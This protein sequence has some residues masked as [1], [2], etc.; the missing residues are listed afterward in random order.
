MTKT[1]SVEQVTLHGETEGGPPG[2]AVAHP[3]AGDQGELHA[4]RI[5]GSAAGA[6]AVE[7]VYHG[8]PIQIAP[9]RE[10]HWEAL[11]GLV[12]LRAD[13]ALELQ[14]VLENGERLPAA[15]LQL[16]RTP[17]RSGFE[18][19]MQPLLLTSLG[20]SGSTWLMKMFAAHPEIVVMRRFPYES[21]A[22]KYWMHA[23][24]VL[25]DPASI[26]L[27]AHPDSFHSDRW[28]AGSNPY[29]D[30]PAIE[31]PERAAWLAREH[32]ERLAR[33]FQ[34]SVE[35]WYVTVAHSQGQERPRYFA[36][37]HLWPNFL[38]MLMRELYPDAREIFLVRDFRDVALSA[39]GTDARRG[40]AG[41]GKDP[42]MSDEDYVRDVVTRMATDL[43]R[44]WESRAEGAHLVRYEDMAHRPVETLAGLLSY[45]DVDAAP[46]TVERLLALASQ[47]VPDLPGSSFDPE[48]VRRHR[49]S[50]SPQDSIGRWRDRDGAFR[51]VLDEAL[52]DALDAFGYERERGSSSASQNGSASK[53]APLLP[54]EYEHLIEQVRETADAAIPRNA[55][56]LVVS[57]GD[58]ELLRIGPRRALHF[59]QDDFGGYAGYH[60]QDSAAAIEL[61]EDM[62]ARGAQ[63]LVL[64]RTDFWWLDFYSGLDGHLASN[65]PLIA[66]NGECKVFELVTGVQTPLPQPDE[67]A[68]RSALPSLE[69]DELLR[70]LLPTD[71]RV[72]VVTGGGGA[73][74]PSFPASF[75]VPAP[76]EDGG[77]DAVRR[78]AERERAEFLVIPAVARDRVHMGEMPP[79]SSGAWRI[80]TRQEHV[81]DVWERDGGRQSAV[82]SRQTPDI[83][84]RI[85]DLFGRGS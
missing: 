49:G 52:G 11:V 2:F 35:Q 77:L 3:R 70:A 30:P 24:K 62:R 6:R 84:R 4:L 10:A 71:A 38:P 43:R 74:L 17:L 7:I 48:L 56:V 58:E 59:P 51:A 8:R 69:L 53:S 14:V 66:S 15:T 21:S 1:Y 55:T 46:A 29:F 31:D 45:L 41:F 42:G 75:P 33:F 73:G 83:V 20:R 22:A 57:R 16:R 64:P 37:K 79:E 47:D 72:A 13:A 39:L 32:V 50:G 80:V 67:T 12:G 28:W 63:Y 81:G 61:L 9:V 60:P 65:Y 85:M 40:Y 36:E 25:S 34:E 26:D 18:P 23:M 27:S 5:S 44:S 78:D 19:A 68:L 76:G 54:D 82:G